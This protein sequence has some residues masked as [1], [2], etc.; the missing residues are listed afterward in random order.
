M[1]DI[2][3]SWAVPVGIA[4]IIGFVLFLLRKKI[5]AG[6]K[7]TAQFFARHKAIVIIFIIVLIAGIIGGGIF[8]GWRLVNQPISA[9]PVVEQKKEAPAE[10]K[11]EETEFVLILEVAPS[12][13]K[14]DYTEKTLSV[15]GS[16][17]EEFDKVWLQD[18]KLS[19]NIFLQKDKRQYLL[20]TL[21][22]LK[23]GEYN[24]VVK[25]Q[26][27]EVAKKEK[28]LVVEENPYGFKKPSRWLLLFVFVFIVGILFWA[29]WGLTQ[30]KASQTPTP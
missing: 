15:T 30:K 16:G 27:K 4:V 17:F 20:A 2:L 10:E 7:K 13:L 26:G 23:P 18:K 29:F 28:A 1:L 11:K 21:P 22:R 24:V 5:A 8:L 3:L 12:V 19:D 6:L 25:R 14:F 9:P